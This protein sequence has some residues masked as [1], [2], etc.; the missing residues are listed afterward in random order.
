MTFV[1]AGRA[2]VLKAH[3]LELVLS[4]AFHGSWEHSLITA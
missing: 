1:G 3:C 4:E 2:K